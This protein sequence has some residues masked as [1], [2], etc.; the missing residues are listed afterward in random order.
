[1][2]DLINLNGKVRGKK[3]IKIND[4]IMLSLGLKKLLISD[5]KIFAI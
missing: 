2:F 4:L 3:A 5:M 1:M